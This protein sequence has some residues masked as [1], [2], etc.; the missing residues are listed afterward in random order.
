MGS[1]VH[2]GVCANCWQAWLQQQT[3]LINHYGLNVR[4]P[5]ARQF[6]TQ[7]TEAFLFAAKPPVA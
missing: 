4:D 6:L 2:Q 3:A 1:R 7:Q 5:Q